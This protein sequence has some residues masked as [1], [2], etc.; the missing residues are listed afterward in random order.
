MTT[1]TERVD[2]ALLVIHRFG[3][4]GGDHH[5]TWV[6]DQVVRALLENEAEY[7][8]WVNAY[9]ACEHADDGG[10]CDYGDDCEKRYEWETGIAP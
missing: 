6:S 10:V 2:D 4:I 3:Q 1:L 9:E 5:K 7:T 8:A